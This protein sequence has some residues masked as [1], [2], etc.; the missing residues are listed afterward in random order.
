MS[1]RGR[2]SPVVVSLTKS[3]KS[4][5]RPGPLGLRQVRTTPGPTLSRMEGK[6]GAYSTGSL[7]GTRSRTFNS[8]PP[9]KLELGT[10]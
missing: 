10:Q 2:L 5:S 9:L 4:A 7:G 1:Q 6:E 3:P 8:L